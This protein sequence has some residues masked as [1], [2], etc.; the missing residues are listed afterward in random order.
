[1]DQNPV[2]RQRSL[3]PQTRSQSRNRL[4]ADSQEIQLRGHIQTAILQNF[5]STPGGFRLQTS[6]QD[7]G[8]L[9]VPAQHLHPANPG[10]FQS[11]RQME[12][13]VPRPYQDSPQLP[14][15]LLFQRKTRH[16]VEIKLPRFVHHAPESRLLFHVSSEI[17]S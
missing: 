9:R 4:I 11:R 3:F 14:F 10:L 2:L 17:I 13:H 6:S 12:S 16:Q 1:M 15:P 5:Q 7:S 8:V